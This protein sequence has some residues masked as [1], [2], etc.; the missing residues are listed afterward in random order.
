MKTA[1][2]VPSFSS[3]KK[4]PVTHDFDILGNKYFLKVWKEKGIVYV[5][6]WE[7]G[8]LQLDFEECYAEADIYKFEVE[9]HLFHVIRDTI[10]NRNILLA[11][12][13]GNVQSAYTIIDVETHTPIFFDKIDNKEF[14]DLI[15]NLNSYTTRLYPKKVVIEMI[16]NMGMSAGK[17][18][19]D[20]ARW[21]GRFQQKSID[22]GLEVELIYRNEVKMSL[23][24]HPRAKD[25][26]IRQALIDEFGLIPNMSADEWQSFA[27][28]I[29]S[30]RKPFFELLMR[31]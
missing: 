5:Q 20:T 30:L 19:F 26:N 28:G 18:L 22:V 24:G 6:G 17:T 29:T 4:E 31:R 1:I 3:I 8:N 7:Y 21:I 16:A 12:D 2:K 14:L 25:G 10:I 23:C 27:V 9:V 11:I 15:E 13:P